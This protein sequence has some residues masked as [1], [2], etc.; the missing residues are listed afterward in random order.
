MADNEIR[1]LTDGQHIRLRTEMYLGSRSPHTQ[2]IVNWTG[3]QL[4]PQEMTWVP[5]V[6]AAWREIM[7]NALDE[8]VSHGHGSRIDITYDEQSCAFSVRDDGRG[9]PLDW[10]DDEKMH[11]ATMVLVYPRAGRNFGERGAVRG[12]NGVGASCTVHC[13]QTAT[14]TVVRDGKK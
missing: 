5:A 4:Q 11:K 14:L 9:I 8:V 7:D 6:Y 12:T 10:D 1:K 3:Q 13:S 2:T